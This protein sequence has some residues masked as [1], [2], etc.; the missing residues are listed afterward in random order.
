MLISGLNNW[1][2]YM[3][4]IPQRPDFSANQYAGMSRDPDFL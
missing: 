4:K 3:D 2:R 1:A